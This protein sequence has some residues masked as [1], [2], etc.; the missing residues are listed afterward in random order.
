MQAF[1]RLL[2]IL[3]LTLGNGACAILNLGGVQ[4]PSV[5][6][7]NLTPGKISLLAQEFQLE[8]LVQNPNPFSLPV[9]GMSYT[10]QLNGQKFAHGVSNK[11]TEIPAFSQQFFNI[12]VTTGL[13]QLFQQL[14][15]AFSGKESNTFSYQLAGKLHLSN[16]TTPLNFST[17]DS[18]QIK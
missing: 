10:L 17:R 2:L 1:V 13:S 16:L 9:Q 14:Q 6:L 8:I 7:T 15:N 18:I 11:V 3:A 4:T 5:T 12:S